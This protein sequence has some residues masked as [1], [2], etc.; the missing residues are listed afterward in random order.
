MNE[1]TGG[2]TSDVGSVTHQGRIL[3]VDD[4]VDMLRPHTRLLT[5]SGYDVDTVM[6]GNDA[7][8]LLE[9]ESYDLVLLDEQMPGL[10]GIEVL[11]RMRRRGRRV[12]VVMVTKSEADSTMHEAIGREVDDYIVKPTSP[13]QVLS[14]VTRLL[15]GAKL[16]HERIARE[17]TS[18]FGELRRRVTM[19]E[20]WRDWTD[21]FSRMVDWELGLDSAGETD[22]L[23]VLDT[24]RRDVRR[25]FCDMVCA[26]Y[27][28]WVNENAA[29]APPLSVDVMSEFFAPLLSA[30]EP[31]MLVVIDCL[32]LDQWR[33]IAPSLADYF[34]IDEA[35]HASILPTA[36]PFSRNAIFSGLFPDEI[37][38]RRPGWYES[39]EDEG[40]NTFEGELLKDHVRELAGRDIQTHYEKVFTNDQGQSMLQ[41]LPGYLSSPSVTALVFGFVDLLTHGRSESR[42]IF[43]VAR[44][45]GALRSLTVT[46][47][48]RSA[49]LGALR[50]A[51]RRGVRVLLTTDHGSI[52]CNRPATV[53]ARRDA[54][55]NL[56]YKFGRDL[57][58][59]DP[60]T[61]FVVSDASALRL[62][63]RGYRNN[64]ALCREDHYFVYPTKL[65]EYQSRYRDSFLHGG[66]SPEEMILPVALLTPRS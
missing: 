19:A 53:F 48:E 20:S 13:R 49:A 45:A 46:W 37:E 55:Q 24:L 42:L 35:L 32:R 5:S 25:E 14:V 64:Y 57:R 33:A 12:P 31:V 16:R 63:D 40:Y 54:T 9:A 2:G 66:V 58:V 27:P 22:L 51:S 65:R 29:D 39:G 34:E 56:R 7:L 38:A 30:G 18:G 50:E 11:E 15:A 41:R 44:D 6:N 28:G 23:E 60:S 26:R 47:F 36:T 8:E 1:T 10:R 4:E 21:L 52:H 43:E 62:P 3:W 59:E 61:A 17:F